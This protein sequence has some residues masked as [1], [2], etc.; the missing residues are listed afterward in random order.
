MRCKL[1]A[2]AKERTAPIDISGVD[3]SASINYLG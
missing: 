3:V 1:I 2:Q